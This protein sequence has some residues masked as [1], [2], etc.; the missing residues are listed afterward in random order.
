M[1]STC[2]EKP[3]KLQRVW[4]MPS[5]WTFECD[6]IKNMIVRYVGDGLNWVDPFAG[7]STFAEFRND[8][9]QPQPHSMDALEFLKTQPTAKRKGALFD[10]P[11]SAEQCLRRYTAKVKGTMGREEYWAKCKDELA[12]TI[13]PGGFCLSF[14]W[15]SVGLGKKRGFGIIEILLV[16]HGAGHYDTICTVERKAPQVTLG[17]CFYC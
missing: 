9:E 16:C 3:I 8:I 17:D 12:R 2:I 11:Y 13:M 1:N 6:P 15:N 4:A 10:P 7:K 5:I 14:C